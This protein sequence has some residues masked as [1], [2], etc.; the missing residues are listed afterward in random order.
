MK[1]VEE[2][3]GFWS[4]L[5]NTHYTIEPIH[6]FGVVTFLNFLPIGNKEAYELHQMYEESIYSRYGKLYLMRLLMGFNA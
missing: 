6:G 3:A 2:N 5:Y 4:G 1:E